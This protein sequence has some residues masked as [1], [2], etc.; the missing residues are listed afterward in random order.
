MINKNE[1]N[2]E[3]LKWSVKGKI[4]F[5]IVLEIKKKELTLDVKYGI[6]IVQFLSL[7]L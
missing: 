5:F 2:I 3:V 4:E 6:K 1:Q 7:Y